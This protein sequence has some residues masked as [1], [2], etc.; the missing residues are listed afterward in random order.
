MK[1]KAKYLEA[2][3]RQVEVSVPVVNKKDNAKVRKDCGFMRIEFENR[4]G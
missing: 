3:R 2:A 4:G 1:E